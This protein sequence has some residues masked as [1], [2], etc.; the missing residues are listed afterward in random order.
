MTFLGRRTAMK[1]K[2]QP[3]LDCGY[4]D[5]PQGAKWSLDGFLRAEMQNISLRGV[6]ASQESRN[7]ELLIHL[8][9]LSPRAV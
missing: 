3:L 8:R 6:F 9:C 1:Y 5:R 7:S 2:P 4:Y